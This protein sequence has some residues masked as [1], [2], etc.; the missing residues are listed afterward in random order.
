MTQSIGGAVIGPGGVG[1]NGAIVYAWKLSRIS[2]V[3]PAQD[4]VAPSGVADA[5]PVV[6]ST[7]YGGP[8]QYVIP[9]PTSEPYA[10]AVQYG[11]HVFWSLA[12][13]M[14][15]TDGTSNTANAAG[16]VGDTGTITTAIT[17]GAL[18]APAWSQVTGAIATRDVVITVKMTT[19][20]ADASATCTLEM[21][22]P[23]GFN[24]PF[25]PEAV[26][27][28]APFKSGA[29]KT[30]AVPVPAGWELTFDYGA[31][32]TIVFTAMY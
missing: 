29:V 11:G 12:S 24:G 13:D 5:G 21:A 23:G 25:T 7:A 9:C 10:I 1:V 8:G 27:E 18:T 26:W 20:A 30:I 6:T 2:G 31:N 17:S 15:F 16:V 3:L 32:M 28:W 19:S 4:G 14:D 22:P